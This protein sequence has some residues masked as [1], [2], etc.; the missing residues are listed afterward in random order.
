VT[1]GQQRANQQRKEPRGLASL[2]NIGV[3]LWG[4]L[5]SLPDSSDLLCKSPQTAN[6]AWSH[7]WGT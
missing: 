1:F 5:S 7:T 4:G 6:E 2:P 3:C